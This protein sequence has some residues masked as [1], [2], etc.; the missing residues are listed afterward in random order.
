MAIHLTNQPTLIARLDRIDR[1][2][3]QAQSI[4]AKGGITRRKVIAM[5]CGISSRGD[6]I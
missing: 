6:S 2:A 5:S 4:A 3:N 1:D